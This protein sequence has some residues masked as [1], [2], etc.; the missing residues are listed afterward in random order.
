[1]S[2]RPLDRDNMYFNLN[3][4]T[5]LIAQDLSELKK[6]G[7]SVDAQARAD[8]L[9]TNNKVDDLEEKISSELADM[10]TLVT[11]TTLAE[12]QLFFD[13]VPDNT[14]IKFPRKTYTFENVLIIR[15]KHNLK[16]DFSEALFI[17]NRHGYGL[18]E[19]TMCS[20]IVHFG[21]DFQGA[22]NFYPNTFVDGVLKNEK[23]TA[24]VGFGM[25]RN[26]EAVTTPYNN[27][28]LYNCGIG[29]LVHNGCVNVTV[30][31]A[32]AH[33]FNYAGIS[34]GFSGDGD[35]AGN[36]INYCLDVT[37]RDCEV[38]GNFD[39]GIQVKGVKGFWVK[40]N[41][42]HDNGHPDATANDSEVNPGY[43]VT[44][45]SGLY[46]A[47]N[48]IVS[49]NI[50]VNNKRKGID[51]HGGKDF[52][53]VNN[54]V[55][56]SFYAAIM[57]TDFVGQ[58]LGEYTIEGNEVQDC[59]NGSHLYN[60]AI[61][62]DGLGT[63]IIRNNVIKNCGYNPTHPSTNLRTNTGIFVERGVK[64]VIGNIIINSGYK[65]GILVSDVTRVHIENNKIDTVKTD[66]P[67]RIRPNDGYTIPFVT[68]INNFIKNTDGFGVL[69]QQCS[70]G[71]CQMN[72]ITNNK[73]DGEKIFVNSSPNVTPSNNYF[74][75]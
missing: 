23:T 24:T 26:G 22:G 52:K 45:R 12:V 43:G 27:G 11:G 66:M 61:H 30:E 5:N 75:S 55:R 40:N 29:V 54:R 71:V 25:Y 9:E 13:N 31:K 15:N 37:V 42:I 33:G 70:K 63:A 17:T 73:T 36:P 47:E 65:S 68:V 32:V 41:Y 20:N 4:P 16:I 57:V 46:V 64:Y 39:C 62:A 59:A 49:E 58:P 60:E 2:N 1:M 53:I 51:S 18:V 8:I 38:Y 50:C 74:F 44:L 6:G 21:G 19:Y 48:G 14:K 56:G 10:V 28:Y 34:V 35:T 67:I 69:V 3:D 7:N 72:Q